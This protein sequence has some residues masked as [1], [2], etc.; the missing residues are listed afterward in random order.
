MSRS[1]RRFRLDEEGRNEWRRPLPASNL[2][3]RARNE[4]C[5]FSC[6]GE[7]WACSPTADE[8]RI[9]RLRIC[10]AFVKPCHVPTLATV[11]VFDEPFSRGASARLLLL[12]QPWPIHADRKHARP[13]YRKSGRLM[14]NDCGSL[15][16]WRIC[17]NF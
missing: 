4:P 9:P 10:H 3:K 14:A 13:E 16:K 6:A 1:L 12:R 5:P 17:R 2:K 11:E 8:D 15:R 7:R